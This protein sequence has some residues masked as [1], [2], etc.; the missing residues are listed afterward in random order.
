MLK[1][2]AIDSF[3][4]VFDARVFLPIS[5]LMIFQQDKQDGVSGHMFWKDFLQMDRIRG[6]DTINQ[7]TLWRLFVAL[8]Y[9]GGGYLCYREFVAA[10]YLLMKQDARL[11]QTLIFVAFSGDRG[12]HGQIATADLKQLLL[13][14]VVGTRTSK[15]RAYPRQNITM[16]DFD[17]LTSLMAEAA[18]AQSTEREQGGTTNVQSHT[19]GSGGCLLYTSDAADE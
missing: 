3:C 19:K 18:I 17:P 14:L 13:A 6:S 9:R 2:T 4:C 5:C 16:D 7:D 1:V 10:C 12:V 15:W 8:N 11:K